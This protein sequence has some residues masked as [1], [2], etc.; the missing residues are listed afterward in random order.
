MGV[1]STEDDLQKRETTNLTPALEFITSQF[2]VS[3][4]ELKQK[5]RDTFKRKRPNFMEREGMN[6]SAMAHSTWE[7]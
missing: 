7:G 6:G 4:L 3:W 2:S 1:Q 5:Q